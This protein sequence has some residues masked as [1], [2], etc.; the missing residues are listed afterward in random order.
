MT[1]PTWPESTAD[2]HQLSLPHSAS[3]GSGPDD[4]FNFKSVGIHEISSMVIATAS[5]G[6]PI[7]EEQ[8]QL[9]LSDSTMRS[10]HSETVPA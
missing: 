6:V 2:P 1:K 4:E 7:S 10:S 5:V 9:C 3:L 8:V